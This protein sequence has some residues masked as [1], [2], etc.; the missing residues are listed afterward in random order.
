[1]LRWG[2]EICDFAHVNAIEKKNIKVDDHQQH[3]DSHRPTGPLVSLVCGDA[4]ILERY[5]FNNCSNRRLAFGATL[6]G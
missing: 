3:A 4:L 5:R 2:E 6:K 1:M